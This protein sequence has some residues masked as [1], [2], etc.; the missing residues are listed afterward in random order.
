MSIDTSRK[1]SGSIL[2]TV[3]AVIF[4]ITA[5]SVGWYASQYV[6][7]VQ[8][9]RFDLSETTARIV[10][11]EQQNTQVS[12]RFGEL[13]HLHAAILAAPDLRTIILNAQPNA[14]AA[15]GRVYWSNSEGILL[16]ASRLPPASQQNVY[17]LWFVIPP[18]PI[19]A[20]I[21][22]MEL[23]EGYIFSRV[24]VPDNTTFPTAIALTLEASGGV[25]TPSGNVLLLGRTDQ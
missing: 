20:G 6:N 23:Q 16:S 7:M 22:T 4:L 9:L 18:N 21:F 1:S 14:T 10:S 2:F 24:D 3:T 25:K 19:S 5:A 13:S 17:Q 15:A 11:L 12:R 8:S